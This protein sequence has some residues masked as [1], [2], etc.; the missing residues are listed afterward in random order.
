MQHKS[1][2]LQNA[3]EILKKESFAV[4]FIG[5]SM[6]IRK[7]NWEN[8]AQIG[9]YLATKHNKHILICSGKEDAQKGEC[10]KNAI[11]AQLD[12]SEFGKKS[13]KFILNLCGQTTLI[14]LGA[15][16]NNADLLISNETSCVH[17]SAMLGKR[18]I[19]LCQGNLLGRYCPYPQG[20]KGY[21]A[22]FH[23]AINNK[24][25]TQMRKKFEKGSKLNINEISVKDVQKAVDK[26]LSE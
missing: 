4:L 10:V 14:Q 9:A 17:F 5:A 2:N 24:N 8:Y 22:I 23:P 1:P 6:K 15:I 19:V 18:L 25:F 20:T 13:S 12:E 3:F 11:L 26:A 7:W 21:Y 16:L